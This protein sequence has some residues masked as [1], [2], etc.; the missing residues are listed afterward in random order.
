MKSH[1]WIIGG[2]GWNSTSRG[3][4]GVD[5]VLAGPRREHPRR[6][7]RFT[8]NTRRQSSKSTPVSAVAK[9]LIERQAHPQGPRRH[10]HDLRLCLCGSGFDRRFTSSSCSTRAE[11]EAIQTFARDRRTVYPTTVSKGG[12]TRTQTVVRGRSLRYW[13]LAALQ[14]DARGQGR[15]PVRAQTPKGTLT[16]S[17]ATS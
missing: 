17:S 14:P 12:M 10:G 4:G 2:D 7:H 5:H 6:R 3:Y 15:E 13:H 11:A 9:C 1:Q 16:V 8:S